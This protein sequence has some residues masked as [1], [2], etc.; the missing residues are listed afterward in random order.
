MKL[1][2]N[3]IEGIYNYC[4][5]WCERCTFTSKCAVYASEQ[6]LSPEDNDINNKAFWD[7]IAKS[8][9]DTVALIHKV[10]EKEGIV[11]DTN[12]PEVE[13]YIAN[14]KKGKEESEQHPL[15]KYCKQYMLD[16]RML[17]QKNEHLKD[18]ASELVQLTELGIKDIEETQIDIDKASDS[19]EIVRWYLFQ[20]QVKFMR[21]FSSKEDEDDT[22]E[23]SNNDSN[24]SAKVAL[25]ATDRCLMAWQNIMQFLPAIEDDVLPLLALLQKIQV[26]GE[27]TFPNARAFIRVGLDE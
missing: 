20:I 5:R 2:P 19:L 11:L 6:G 25:I 4:D 26:L 15:I 14:R 23:F 7:N 21:A 18:K 17:L 24:G 10:A 22:D 12:S 16:A 8:F 3:H 13:G 1:N 9:A 27:Q